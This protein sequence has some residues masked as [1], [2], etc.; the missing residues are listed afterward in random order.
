MKISKPMIN[1]NTI[2][3][4]KVT[5]SIKISNCNNPKLIYFMLQLSSQPKFASKTCWFLLE[6]SIFCHS[7]KNL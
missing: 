6:E 2:I 7:P 4:T 3:E 5:K 1:H